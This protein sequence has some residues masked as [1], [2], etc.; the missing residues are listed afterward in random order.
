MHKKLEHYIYTTSDI[1]LM[2]SSGIISV[3]Q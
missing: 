3:K 2:P 1:P